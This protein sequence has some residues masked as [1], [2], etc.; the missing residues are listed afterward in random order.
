MG[1]STTGAA[2]GA[3]AAQ[4]FL[5]PTF[6]A[7]RYTDVTFKY[8]MYGDAMGYLYVA[9]CTSTS[10][11]V[12]TGSS[13]AVTT[14]WVKKGEQNTGRTDPWKT[15]WVKI[16]ATDRRLRFKGTKGSGSPNWSGD[17]SIDEV[18][19]YGKAITGF[20]GTTCP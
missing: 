12:C 14:K 19:L 1:G 13:S 8:H 5:S 3:G 18:R 7:G 17:M 15:A 9:T 11:S 20:N 2:N 4:Y 16:G 10:N 6:T